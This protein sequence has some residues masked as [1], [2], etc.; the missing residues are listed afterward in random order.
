MGIEKIPASEKITCDSCQ[1]ICDGKK[2]QRKKKG[3][4]ILER[5]AL[6][7]QG[8]AAA[9][10]TMEIILCDDCEFE[11]SQAINQAVTLIRAT[12]EK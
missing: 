1:Q 8:N 10:A 4:Y 11:I 6:D 7:M 5:A 12:N 2:V 9:D 3:K